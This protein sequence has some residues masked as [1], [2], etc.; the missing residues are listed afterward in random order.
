MNQFVENLRAFF[1]NLTDRERRLLAILG[2]TL[3]LAVVVLPAWLLVQGNREVS[4][5]N[6]AIR[7]LIQ[8]IDSGHGKLVER[9]AEQLARTERL[10]RTPPPLASYIET[11]ARKAGYQR[12]LEVKD[13]PDKRQGKYLRKHTRGTLTSVDLRTAIDTV[14]SLRNS[15]FPVSIERLHMKH[16]QKGDSYTVELGVL[17]F[18]KTKSKTK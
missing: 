1:E 16:Y 5:E 13:E 7:E 9:R 6:A 10:Q 17:A 15:E 4:S 11:Q 8:R 3:G 14:V 2:G 18:Q 12:P